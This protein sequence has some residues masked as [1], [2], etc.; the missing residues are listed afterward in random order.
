MHFISILY[1]E[2][3]W[4]W[5]NLQ[6]SDT[7]SRLSVPTSIRISC[8]SCLCLYIKDPEAV[9]QG[10]WQ[11]FPLALHFTLAP[12]RL[13][14]THF[15]VME[16][17]TAWS[18]LIYRYSVSGFDAASEELSSFIRFL[19]STPSDQ[20]AHFS[21]TQKWPKSNKLEMIPKLHQ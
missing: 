13:Q 14:Y 4:G 16:L 9:A 17:L 10:Q 2:S 21:W 7:F 1:N 15:W 5:S 3:F 20:S 11:N 18:T 12:K 8:F 6:N 19:R